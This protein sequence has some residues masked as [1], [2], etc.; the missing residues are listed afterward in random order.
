MTKPLIYLAE[1][2]RILSKIICSELEKLDYEVECFQDGY[3]LLKKVAGKSPALIISDN[4]LAGI[5]GIELCKILKSGS[6]K[7]SIPFIL[8]SADDSV[9]DF[10]MSEVE[11]NRVVLVNNQNIDYLIQN[12]QILSF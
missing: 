4:S 9:L 1:P 2:S 3:S 6:S 12:W 5:N 7:Y 8:I 11:A 10:W